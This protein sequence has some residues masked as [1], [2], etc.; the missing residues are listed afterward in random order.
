MPGPNAPLASPPGSFQGAGYKML[1][2][3]AFLDATGWRPRIPLAD[4][5]RRLI[6]AEYA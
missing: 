1:D 3:S 6:A 5:V 4:G 2:S